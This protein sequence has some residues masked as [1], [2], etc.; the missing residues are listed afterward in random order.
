MTAPN[1]LAGG[2]AITGIF[3][4]FIGI[5]ILAHSS[6]LT[7]TI[8]GTQL[9]DIDHTRSWIG[10]LCYPVARWINRR[11]GHRTLTHSL[12]C[13]TT[14][15]LLVLL[16]VKLS[17]AHPHIPKAF[18]LAYASHLLLDMMT[19]QGVP[20]F[21]PFFRNPCVLPGKP[22]LRF[23][24]GN[25]ST[26][27]LLFCLFCCSLLFLRPLMQTGFWTQYNRLF[28]SP[29]HLLS[30]WKKSPTAVL[31]QYQYK[32]GSQ[33][34]QGCGHVIEID[35]Q[36]C[37]LWENEDW[38]V[39]DNDKIIRIVPQ[40]TPEQLQLHR[41]EFHG[42]SPDS[43][44]RLIPKRLL[45]RLEV[46]APTSFIIQS[47]PT[48]QQGKQFKGQWLQQI[49]FSPLPVS[50]SLEQAL[51]T[52]DIPN[53]QVSKL[54]LQI[55]KIQNEYQQSL[56]VYE[57]RQ[58]ERDEL[59]R[60]SRSGEDLYQKEMAIRALRSFKMPTVPEPVADEV[61]LLMAQIQILEDKAALDRERKR[62]QA[63]R[64]LLKDASVP[65][66]LSGSLEYISIQ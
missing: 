59:L 1:H 13:W 58:R 5:N 32:E 16:L 34:S 9:P 66:R 49:H 38:T 17:D 14:L 53:P 37:I 4:S 40:R 56:D 26:E 54:K 3:G 50:A 33:I 28:G 61:D 62:Q 36:Q 57:A 18:C 7:A 41:L 60:A 27:T 64:K 15:S 35:G 52:A 43:L 25:L 51:P 39:L 45:K 6:V 55:K 8:V 2:L 31:A 24:T 65:L 29:K 42:L 44:H 19:L 63:R 23:R 22:E 12:L 48:H 46:Y 21:Y 30:E 47:G 11:Y 20:L 10:I